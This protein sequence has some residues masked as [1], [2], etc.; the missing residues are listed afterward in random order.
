MVDTAGGVR[1]TN[2]QFNVHFASSASVPA[3]TVQLGTATNCLLQLRGSSV[4]IQVATNIVSSNSVYQWQVNGRQ[5]AGAAR[6]RLTLPF[7]NY[8]DA[9]RYSVTIQ[10]GTTRTVLPGVAVLVLDP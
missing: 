4:T 5:I 2:I 10:N 9:G 8:S 1:G 6:D 7:L 3:N